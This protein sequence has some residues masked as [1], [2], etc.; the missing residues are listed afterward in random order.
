V[1]KGCE[2]HDRP[3]GGVPPC[4]RRG[5]ISALRVGTALSRESAAV[6]ARA[7]NRAIPSRP[8]RCGRAGRSRRPP[9]YR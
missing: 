6:A 1:Y 9:S 2:S 7:R 5:S 4:P 3:R 8:L